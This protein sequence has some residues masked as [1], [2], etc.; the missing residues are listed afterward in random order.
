MGRSPSRDGWRAWGLGRFQTHRPP[1][2]EKRPPSGGALTRK[3]EIIQALIEAATWRKLLRYAAK[4][5]R[6]DLALTAIDNILAL[7]E[8]AI[9]AFLKNAPRRRTVRPRSADARPAIT[10]AET[11]RDAPSSP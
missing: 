7:Q 5:K 2:E 3:G 11:S 1:R 4:H 8:K 10:P 6:M 9:R